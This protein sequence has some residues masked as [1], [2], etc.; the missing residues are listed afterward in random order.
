MGAEKVVDVKVIEL[1][2]DWNVYPRYE[3]ESLDHTNLQRMKKAMVAGIKLPPIIINEKDN[4]IV[5]G[6]HRTKA[7]ISLYGDGATIRAIK[8]TYISES[9]MF[10][11]SARLNACHGLPLSPRDKVH[12]L[13]K[14]RR[15]KIPTAKIAESLGM[16]TD[17]AM[18]FLRKRTAVAQSGEKIPLSGGALALAGKTLTKE[19][20]YYV[21]KSCN[22]TS[23]QL[24]SRLLLNALKADAIIF[25][26]KIIEQLKELRLVIEKILLEVEA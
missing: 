11:D 23:A 4:R 13:Q 9:D 18:E 6:F 24:Y 1:I 15:F 7:M 26:E 3:S 10:L 8:R 12:V 21:R 2:F 14:A 17:A 22:G 25:S 19:Q 20:E 16:D 5:D